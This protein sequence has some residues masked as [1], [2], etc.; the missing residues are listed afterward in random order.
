M[1][2]PPEHFTPHDLIRAYRGRAK[3]RFGQHFLSDPSILTRIAQL[4]DVSEGDHVLEIGP[5]CGTLTWALLDAGARVLS[6]ELDRDLAA[7][8]RESFSVQ[9]LLEH[10]FDLLEGD[11]LGVDLSEALRSRHDG[12]WRVAA[13]LPYNVATQL[14]FQLS[15]TCHDQIA[16]MALM[17]QR[18]VAE[19]LAARPG[20]SG[21]SVVSLTAQLYWDIQIGMT[22][23]PGAFTPPPKVHSAVATFTP[24]PGTRIPDE[25]TRARFITLVRAAFQKRRKQLPNGLKGLGIEPQATRDALDAMG[26]SPDARPETLGFEH[27]AQLAETL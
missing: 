5:G 1:T 22:L 4:A 23:P 24:V 15:E 11:A 12:K 17:F 14:L 16:S 20:D 18:E 27:F 26:L 13:N 21:Y 3:H 10:T 25:A 2:Q 9:L 19:R 6:V 7:F 8:L